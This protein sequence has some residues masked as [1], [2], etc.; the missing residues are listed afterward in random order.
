MSGE[1][2][3]GLHLRGILQVEVANAVDPASIHHICRA[4]LQHALKG[5]QSHQKEGENHD[6]A[7]HEKGRSQVGDLSHKSKGNQATRHGSH[8]ERGA[9][10]GF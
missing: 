6:Q 9:A 4:R 3:V 10:I 8:K 5:E 1:D 7:K 2:E